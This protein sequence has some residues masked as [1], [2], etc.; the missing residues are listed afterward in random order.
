MGS[1]ISKKGAEDLKEQVIEGRRGR[2][3]TR[4]IIS[5]LDELHSL[6]LPVDF[7]IEKLLLDDGLAAL[8]K[9]NSLNFEKGLVTFTPSS[10]SKCERELYY[11]AKHAGRDEQSF[12]PYQ[13][14]WTR[15][16]S[17]VH[18]AVQRD[19]LY[20][21]K[22]LVSPK[23]K[24]Q[25]TRTGSPAWER[26]LRHVRKFDHNGVRVY[27]LDD[28]KIGFEFKTKSTTI[29][30]IGSYKLKNA[31]QSHKEQ[32][33]AYSLLFGL[34]EF[35]LLY[36]SLAKD[37]WTKGAEAKPDLRA[38]YL[39]VTNEDRETMLDKF[40]GVAKLVRSGDLPGANTDKCIFCPYKDRCS[41]EGAA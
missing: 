1:L 29:T 41:D 25:R 24:V 20:A 3:L 37:N 8:G 21:E 38:F 17:A 27:T 31:Q 11:K 35:I 19:L 26:N 16:G 10:A 15:N 40:A 7:E 2:E 36:E 30:A 39:E 33:I 12:Y 32:C 18:G 28:S 9:D 34:N 14:R 6:D 4:V 23:F 5:H 13:R 22:Y